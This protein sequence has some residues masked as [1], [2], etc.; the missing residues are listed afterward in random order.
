[1]AA[2]CGGGPQVGG[3][4]GGQSGRGGIGERSIQATWQQVADFA[5]E[6]LVLMPCGFG[7][8]RTFQELEKVSFPDEWKSLPA[9]EQGNVFVVDGSSYFNRPGPRIVDGLELLAQIIHPE[10]FTGPGAKFPGLFRV[11]YALR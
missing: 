6:I 11:P 4:A 10:L 3:L 1:M 2:S 7:I 5:P 8:P 9:V